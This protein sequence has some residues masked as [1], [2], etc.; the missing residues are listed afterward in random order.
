[1]FYLGIKINLP[2]VS[3][4]TLGKAAKH[5]GIKLLGCAHFGF[6]GLAVGDERLL[7]FD[8]KLIEE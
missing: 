4:V 2:T 1:M 5:S 8:S 3:E 6:L 7:H